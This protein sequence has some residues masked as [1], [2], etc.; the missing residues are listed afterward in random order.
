MRMRIKAMVAAVIASAALGGAL[1]TPASADPPLYDYFFG[2][3][4]P[5]FNVSFQDD[6]ATSKE[7][8]HARNDVRKF[9]REVDGTFTSTIERV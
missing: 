9:C 7:T 1:A 4:A 6:D 5:G 8:H 2:C 3:V